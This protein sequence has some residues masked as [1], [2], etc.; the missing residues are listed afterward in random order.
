M[1]K[2]CTWDSGAVRGKQS[3][4]DFMRWTYSQSEKPP[5]TCDEAEQASVT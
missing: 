4:H 1:G 2:N 5:L 3:S